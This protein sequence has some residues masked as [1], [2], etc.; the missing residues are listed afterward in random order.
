MEALSLTP[1]FDEAAALA[2]DG[3]RQYHNGRAGW[4]QMMRY[5]FVLAQPDG[6]Y[7]MHRAMREAL[8]ARCSQ[9]VARIQQGWF[10][11][12]WEGRGETTLAF[13]HR[14]H[15]DPGLALDDWAA[16]HQEALDTLR[17]PQARAL[18][19]WWA[20]I[21][22]DDDDRNALTDSLWGRTNAVLG[23][24]LWRTP[25]APR[26]PLLHR[27]AQHFR[28]A[29]SV[30]PPETEAWAEASLGLAL[31]LIH[32]PAPNA[33]EQL[34]E[35]ME[36]LRQAL[37]VYT[38][39]AYPEPWA[40]TQ[41][42]MGIVWA[43]LPA[44]DPEESA[45]NNLRAIACFE[46]TV[47]VWTE[48][49]HPKIWARAQHNLGV[50]YFLLPSGDREANL[51]CAVEYLEA[52]L[53]VRTRAEFPS[54]WALTQYNLGE[55]YQNMPGDRAAHLDKAREYYQA[56]LE[57]Y[58]E[59]DFPETW[60]ETMNSLGNSWQEMPSG[61]MRRNLEQAIPYYEAA[62]R[63]WTQEDCEEDWNMVQDSL[64]DVRRRLALL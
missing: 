38:P 12:H 60:A 22:L 33:A 29:L 53:R 26:P 48:Q 45:D 34:Q 11:S 63:V 51:R 5:S 44:Q 31:C 8:R 28:A 20:E 58:T 55:V 23:Q 15:L 10:A 52:A 64:R 13:Y 56:A 16:E 59:E 19:T 32:L 14:W 57:V 47:Q 35:A 50:S 7:R 4:E 49:I 40:N 39:E 62:L 46:A 61:D 43:K 21:S 18:L 17:V 25:M 2:L 37:N 6:F 54:G 30:F 36:C 1:K 27:A 9:T 3:E 42:H 24:A 41:N